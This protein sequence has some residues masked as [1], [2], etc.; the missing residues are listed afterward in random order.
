[1]ILKNKEGEVRLLWRLFML[2]VPFLLAA[3]L[4][5]Y[6]PIRIQIRIL[7]GQGFSEAVAISRARYLFLTDPLGVSILGVLQGLLWPMLV[8]LLIRSIEKQTCGLRSLGL[9]LNGKSLMFMIAGLLLGLTMYFGYFAANSIFNQSSIAWSPAKRGILPIFLLSLDM[10]A[11][12]F[13]E[14]TA[15]RAYWQRLLVHRHGMWLGILL[16]SASFV[17]LHLFI[18]PFTGIALL[19]SIL[20]AYLYGVLYVWT[21]SVFLVGT[22]HAIFNLA[23]RLLDQWPSDISLLIVNSLALAIAVILYLRVVK[24]ARIRTACNDLCE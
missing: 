10:L 15:F 17:V 19:A 14:E 22:M 24:V 18:A 6:I 7:M 23:P 12:G 3:Y 4:L 8:C 11:N 5:R 1:M 2:V 21:G 16:V 20:L 9:L 13:G